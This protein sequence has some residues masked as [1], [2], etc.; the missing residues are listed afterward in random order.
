MRKVS[1]Q[2]KAKIKTIFEA[3]AEARKEKS[4]KNRR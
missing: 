4:K 1:K 3:I 2:A